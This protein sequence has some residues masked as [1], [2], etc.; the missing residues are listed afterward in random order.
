MPYRPWLLR[1]FL[2]VF[3]LGLFLSFVV[4]R[5]DLFVVSS[6]T[7]LVAGLKDPPDDPSEDPPEETPKSARNGPDPFRAPKPSQIDHSCTKNT[8][9]I[10]RPA[11]PGNSASGRASFWAAESG[12]DLGA[13]LEVRV[14]RK[15]VR[16]I[17]WT[18]VWTRKV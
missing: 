18:D 11:K 16:V 17:S 8:N 13:F 12:L 7:C 5:R 10:C 4:V 3:C 2:L 15:S 6:L 9:R 14:E 1:T